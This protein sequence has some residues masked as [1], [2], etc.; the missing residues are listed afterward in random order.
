MGDYSPAGNPVDPNIMYIAAF[1]IN[2][3]TD[4]YNNSLIHSTPFATLASAR[5][6]AYNYISIVNGWYADTQNDPGGRYTDIDP[7]EDSVHSNTRVGVF[8]GPASD[9]FPSPPST[10][11]LVQYDDGLDWMS[12]E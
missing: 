2:G 7:L 8:L 1:Y 12:L 10:A 5:T 11:Y 4:L 9:G 6:A 3:K